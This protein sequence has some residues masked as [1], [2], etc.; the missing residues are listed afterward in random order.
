MLISFLAI[1]SDNNCKPDEPA[2]NSSRTD[3]KYAKKIISLSIRIYV[4]M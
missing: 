4:C 1:V 3:V 2:T